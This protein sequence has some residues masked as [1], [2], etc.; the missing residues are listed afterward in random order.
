MDAVAALA[1]DSSFE[2]AKALVATAAAALAPD[3]T[4]SAASG[5]RGAGAGA[6]KAVLKLGGFKPCATWKPA[7][8][9]HWVQASIESAKL[10]ANLKASGV[11]WLLRKAIHAIRCEYEFSVAD[12]GVLVARERLPT[13]AWHSF[14]C[15]EG[16]EFEVAV[17]GLAVAGAL[18]W[19]DA[20][21]PGCLVS[22]NTETAKSG[23]THATSLAFRHD[24]AT[25]EIVITTAQREGTFEKRLRRK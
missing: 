5:W 15:E 17:M 7:W 12:D 3:A 8:L 19:R 9:G 24:E 18:T 2:A 11:P 21:F 10:E 14:R 20:A 16:A 23:S 25:D 4:S 13:R 22:H 1:R 6:T